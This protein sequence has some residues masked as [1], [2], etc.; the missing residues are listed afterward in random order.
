MAVAARSPGAPPE[1]R[2][3]TLSMA[4]VRA[5][6]GLDVGGVRGKDAS[7]APELDPLSSMHPDRDASMAARHLVVLLEHAFL[8]VGE[9][10]VGARLLALDREWRRLSARAP[11]DRALGPST[12]EGRACSAPP[13][14]PSQHLLATPLSPF[15]QRQHSPKPTHAWRARAAAAPQLPA[16]CAH[17]RARWLPPTTARRAR[18][19]PDPDTPGDHHVTSPPRRA[20]HPPLSRAPPAPP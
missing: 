17:S 3:G 7:P 6:G 2:D 10:Q 16:A 20:P 12:V 14:L 8:R 5:S 19:G 4:R 11:I 9:G 18:A 1:L 15:A 13:H